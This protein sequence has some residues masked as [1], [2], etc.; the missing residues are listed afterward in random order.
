MQDFLMFLLPEC[1]PSYCRFCDPE[2]FLAVDRV[3]DGTAGV[4]NVRA[5][6]G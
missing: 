1:M 3:D 5:K 4:L 2:K 6:L